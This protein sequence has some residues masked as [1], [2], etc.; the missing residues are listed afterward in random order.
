NRSIAWVLLV[1]TVAWGL[2][3]YAAMPKRKDP[4][5][6]VRLAAAIVAWPGAPAEKLEQLVTRKI[7]EKIAENSKIEHIDS[8][9]RTG[10]A[11][12]T[13]SVQEGVT[14]TSKEF[15]DIK[16][17]LDTLA[18]TLPRGTQPIQFLKDFGDTTALMLTIASPRAGD[19]EVQL[20]AQQ[21]EK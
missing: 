12:V 17:R 15:D 3:A 2:M 1:A 5:I 10:V 9:T 14:D 7:E 4:E 18:G 13:F 21:I 6:P 16:L 19:V 11:V 8:T 20:R